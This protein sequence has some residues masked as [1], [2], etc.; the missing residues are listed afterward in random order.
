MFTQVSLVW[1]GSRLVDAAMSI[2]FLRFGVDAGLLSRGVFSGALTIVTVIACACW[3]WRCLRR[4]PGI[5][6]RLHPLPTAV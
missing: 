2:G 4:L 5:T 3:G 1:G 6:L